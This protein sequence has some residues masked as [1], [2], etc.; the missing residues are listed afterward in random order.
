MRFDYWKAG[1]PSLTGSLKALNAMIESYQSW[2]VA[3]KSITEKAR[4]CKHNTSSH[5]YKFQGAFIRP[6][7]NMCC[8]DQPEFRSIREPYPLTTIFTF[9][10]RFTIIVYFFSV[11]ATMD[12]NQSAL[13]ISRSVGFSE[14]V[15][16]LDKHLSMY[17][18]FQL[19]I[20]FLGL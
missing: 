13:Q 7:A 6:W 9:Y 18:A 14:A 16:T 15:P 17:P 1:T 5:L 4:H 11:L 3:T 20:L 10:C 12:W 19:D 2:Q 8:Q